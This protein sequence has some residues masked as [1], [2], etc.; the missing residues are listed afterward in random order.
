[1]SSRKDKRNIINKHLA[2]I[3]RQK[4]FKLRKRSYDIEV[5]FMMVKTEKKHN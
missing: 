5:D 1:M 2:I 4:V 3:K